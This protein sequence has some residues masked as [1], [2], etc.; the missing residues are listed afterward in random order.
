MLTAE[1]TIIGSGKKVLLEK[2]RGIKKRD[3]ENWNMTG[4]MLTLKHD[5]FHDD[6]GTSGPNAD[7]WSTEIEH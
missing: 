3:L 6:T 1:L 7:L 4:V 2:G 5:R